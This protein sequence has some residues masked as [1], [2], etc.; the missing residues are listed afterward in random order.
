[1]NDGLKWIRCEL[2]V[3]FTDFDS[4]FL[5]FASEFYRWRAPRCLHERTVAFDCLWLTAFNRENAEPESVRA[6]G[7]SLNFHIATGD[8]K[9]LRRGFYFGSTQ[10]ACS[11]NGADALQ[12]VATV[13]TFGHF[14]I[15]NE[16]NT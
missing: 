16:T 11:A 13:I 9:I 4:A 2:N 6:H 7:R 14:G 15:P 10:K 3:E 12:N 8:L 5:F 1:L